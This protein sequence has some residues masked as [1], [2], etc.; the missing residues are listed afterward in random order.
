MAPSLVGL[1][2]RS[3]AAWWARTE[4]NGTKKSPYTARHVRSLFER[5]VG[6]GAGLFLPLGATMS[7]MSFPTD[8]DD[9]QRWCRSAT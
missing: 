3:S 7:T 4:G 8:L 2:E 6:A 9:V 1:R 5:L